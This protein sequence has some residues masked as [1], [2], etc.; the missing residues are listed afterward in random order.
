MIDAA[1]GVK[2]GCQATTKRSGGSYAST[3]AQVGSVPSWCT[4]TIRPPTTGSK[5]VDGQ[6]HN[7][8]LDDRG[9][10]DSHVSFSFLAAWSN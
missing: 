4:S 2:L 7:P 1:S 10:S 8:L 9:G 6:G 5:A 3:S